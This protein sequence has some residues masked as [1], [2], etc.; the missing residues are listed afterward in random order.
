MVG[1]GNRVLMIVLG[2]AGWT[3]VG[4]AVALAAGA[5]VW[6]FLMFYA[7]SVIAAGVSLG[8]AERWLRVLREGPHPLSPAAETWKPPTERELHE[9]L[10][11]RNRREILAAL[12]LAAGLG[13]LLVCNLSVLLGGVS[14]LSNIGIATKVYLIQPAAPMLTTASLVAFGILSLALLFADVAVDVLE[15]TKKAKTAKIWRRRALRGFLLA[16]LCT[17]GF[18]SGWLTQMSSLIGLVCIA[19]FG[20]LFVLIVRWT[21]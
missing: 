16:A 12:L 3:A 1:K 4:A 10:Q 19:L 13:V 5:S 20:G 6:P 18:W 15:G 9:A 2:V 21:W 8:R 11:T 14:A 17:V 7:A